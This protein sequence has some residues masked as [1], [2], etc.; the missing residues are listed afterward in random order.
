MAARPQPRPGVLDITAYVPGKSD[1]PGA[2][3]VFKLS[4]NETPLG[5]SVKAIAAYRA[6][7]EH[8]EDY[9]DGSAAEL[10]EAI[11]RTY[12]LDAD[13]IVCGAGSDDLLNLLAR[14]YLA[15]GDEAI[16]TTHGFLV[17][18]IATLG[19]G[20]RP[21]VAPEK[22]FTADVDSILAAVTDRTRVVF[23]AN[24]NNPTGTYI[25]FDEVKRLHHALPPHVLLVLDAAYAE[26][27]RRNDYEAGI[28]LVATSDNVVMCRTF[29]KIYGLAALRLGWLYGPAHVV[30]ALNRIR[31][32]F[33]VNAPAIA[34]GVA[35]L[36]DTA[37]VETARL[38][39]ERWLAWL[40]QEIAKL[41]LTVTP[42]AANFILIHF[43]DNKGRTAREA[44]AFLTARGLVLRQ[45]GAYK[46]PNAL[47]MTVGSE[48]ANKL[49]V[50][51]LAEFMGAAR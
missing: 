22:D 47:R 23:L 35:A 15:D 37:H 27:V 38:H 43:P 14:A 3:K 24:P 29:S 18:P 10:R 41:G 9:P 42:S 34:A 1:A 19:T 21:V 49:V 20:A 6:A 7:G 50:G 36:G 30:D 12:G 5:P 39:N 13:R 25:P 8:L 44:D 2:A 4:S 45:V 32:P 46:L 51:A 17:Y 11:G 26:Y 31:G 33:N 16:H 28:E 48:E 40:S